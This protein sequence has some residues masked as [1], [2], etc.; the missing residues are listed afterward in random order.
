MFRKHTRV[1]ICKCVLTLG[2]ILLDLERFI[3]IFFL[4]IK[5]IHLTF[6]VKTKTM[7]YL[8]PFTVQYVA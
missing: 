2:I 4:L 1:I 3:V 5:Q 6:A 8:Q 7:N